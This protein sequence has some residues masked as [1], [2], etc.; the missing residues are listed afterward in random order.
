MH[1]SRALAQQVNHTATTERL[2]VR[3]FAYSFGNSARGG[4]DS[5][6]L[7]RKGLLTGVFAL[8]CVATAAAA[9][10]VRVDKRPPVDV[11]AWACVMLEML[12]GRKPWHNCSSDLQIMTKLL[13]PRNPS[14]PELPKDIVVPLRLR[15]LL[16]QCFEHVPGRRPTPAELVVELERI[17]SGSGTPPP[18]LPPPPPL[19][20]VGGSTADGLS[21]ALSCN[22]RQALTFLGA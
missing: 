22:S 18:P 1:R 11:W 5:A 9:T 7:P 16:E 15:E 8:R 14:S 6:D 17:D 12:A 10:K 3:L 13:H 20:A 21:G 19:H 4:E 2:I